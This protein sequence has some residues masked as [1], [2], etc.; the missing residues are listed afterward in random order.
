M[1]F[2]RQAWQCAEDESEVGDIAGMSSSVTCQIPSSYCLTSLL[3]HQNNQYY[4][5]RLS[6]LHNVVIYMP[7]CLDL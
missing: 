4:Q 3:T 2:G 6:L 1:L 5:H 7:L